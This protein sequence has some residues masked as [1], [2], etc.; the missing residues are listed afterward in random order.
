MASASASK[1]KVAGQTG[2][3]WDFEEQFAFYG[4]Y[5]ANK[6][7]IAIHTVVRCRL[8]HSSFM[9]LDSLS[10]LHPHVVID[11]LS[12]CVPLIWWSTSVLINALL[13]W[14]T[15]TTLLY[16]PLKM[17]FIFNLPLLITT[18]YIL[19]FIGLEGALWTRSV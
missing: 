10:C 11:T 15:T 12:Q 4:P 3:L 16:G 2:S 7:N 19:Y 9:S 18:G 5:H 6:V 13:P 8:Y 1:G 14:H 17:D